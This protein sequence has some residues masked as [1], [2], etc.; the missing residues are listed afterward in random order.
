MRRCRSSPR[1]DVRPTLEHK[2]CYRDRLVW[3]AWARS[4]AFL[5][6]TA[7][8][9]PF[10]DTCGGEQPARRPRLPVLIERESAA[11]SPLALLDN[12]GRVVTGLLLSRAPKEPDLLARGLLGQLAARGVTGSV[13]EPWLERLME[14]RLLRLRFRVTEPRRLIGVVIRDAN[15]LEE[16]A[17]PGARSARAAALAEA[18]RSLEG[19]DHPIAEEARRAL[20]EGHAE[21]SPE[22]ARALAAVALHAAG[23]DVH[24]ERVFSVRHLGSSKALARLR[25]KLEARLG[26]LDALGIREG[27]G[28]VLVGGTGRAVLPVA[29]FDLAVLAP[30]LGL[31]RESALALE[32]LE[33]RPAGLVAVENLT[34]FEACCRGEVPELAGAA[35]VW[36]AGYPGRGAR[37]VVEAAVRAGASVRAWCDLDLDGVRI[38]RMIA[39]WSARRGFFKMSTADVS[40]AP[41]RRPITD[42]ARAAIKRELRDGRDRELADTLGA[43]LEANAWVEQ[44]AFL[45]SS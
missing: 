2:C 24:A 31:S 7:R 43:I 38:A 32:R 26:P 12:A 29:S 37:A 35:F 40:L 3:S 28:I 10:C 21:L 39:T 6:R 36:T 23:G 14:V 30:Y 15:A 19:V 11:A 5:E 34:A 25:P 13:A 44:E 33:C 42:R 20:R 17:H 1:R 27:G 9:V 4:G 22:L 18:E 45:G 16:L 41:R 8:R